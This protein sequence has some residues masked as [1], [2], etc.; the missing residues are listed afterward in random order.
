MGR[1]IRIP[2]ILSIHV[3]HLLR[4]HELRRKTKVRSGQPKKDNYSGSVHKTLERYTK[5]VV[6]RLQICNIL[7][8]EQ[9]SILGSVTS[10]I[11]V[12][13]ILLI[14]CRVTKRLPNNR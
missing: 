10:L 8:D 3:R 13:R 2:S 11:P 4:S 5:S 12:A 14:L 7:S 9:F 6:R 1:Y